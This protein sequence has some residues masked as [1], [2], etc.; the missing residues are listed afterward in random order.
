MRDD[1]APRCIQCRRVLENVMVEMSPTTLA[2]IGD[3]IKHGT[4]VTAAS[5]SWSPEDF[6][7]DLDGNML[8][9]LELPIGV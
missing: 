3:C 8:G 9:Q 7:L 2:V 1:F 5:D 6:H 4:A